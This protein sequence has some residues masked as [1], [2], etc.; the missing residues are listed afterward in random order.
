METGDAGMRTDGFRPSLSTQ[1]PVSAPINSCKKKRDLFQNQACLLIQARE[2]LL[3][4]C[5]ALGVDDAQVV[6]VTVCLVEVHAV[7]HHECIGD[8]ESNEVRLEAARLVGALLQ[9]GD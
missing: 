6:E 7:S 8:A 5:N 4:V 3:V 2:G 1:S 9:Q